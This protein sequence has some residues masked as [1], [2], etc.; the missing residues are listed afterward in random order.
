MQGTIIHIR[1]DRGFCFIKPD[2]PTEPEILCHATAFE[3]RDGFNDA[4]EG[5]R[6]DFNLL[7]SNTKRGKMQADAVRRE[8]N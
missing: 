2:N 8:L 7:P 5:D 3:D 1:A 4:S 6:V